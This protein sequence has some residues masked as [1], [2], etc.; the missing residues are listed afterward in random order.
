MGC[1]DLGR[2]EE[3]DREGLAPA[4]GT[5]PR[6]HLGHRRSVEVPDGERVCVCW[7]VTHPD[8]TGRGRGGWAVRTIPGL[9]PRVSSS[10]GT[11]TPYDQTV[12]TRIALT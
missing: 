7:R 5:K 10:S 6:N 1:R 2:G 11:R 8:A 4:C 3:E 9:A 12:G